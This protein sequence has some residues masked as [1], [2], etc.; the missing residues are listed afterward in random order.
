MLKK[1]LLCLFISISSISYSQSVKGEHR[2]SN[3]GFLYYLLNRQKPKTQMSH[4][5]KAKKDPL[6]QLNGTSY[7]MNRKLKYNVNGDGFD[8]PG[9]GIHEKRKKVKI[10]KFI[11]P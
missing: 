4:F 7:R 3:H 11:K 9:Q 8:M 2:S 1:L 10:K 6:L 5:D